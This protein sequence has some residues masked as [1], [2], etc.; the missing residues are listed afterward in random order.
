MRQDSVRILGG[1]RDE[2]MAFAVVIR[3]EPAADAPWMR[4]GT[5][6]FSMQFSVGM[7]LYCWKM[8]PMFAARLLVERAQL[9][10]EYFDLPRST[11]RAGKLW[12][13]VDCVDNGLSNTH[14]IS[15]LNGAKGVRLC[16]D[17]LLEELHEV[18]PTD[19]IALVKAMRRCCKHHVERAPAPYVNSFVDFQ[20]IHRVD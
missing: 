19:G 17:A 1:G 15:R 13:T 2:S 12:C 6:T 5:L 18:E 9:G 11:P 3:Y 8:K 20:L 4:N 16:C 7:R 14:E 10:A